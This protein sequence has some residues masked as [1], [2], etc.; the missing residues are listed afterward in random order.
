MCLCVC[1]CVCVCKCV[2]ECVSASLC[3]SVRECVCVCVSVCECVCE[4][5]CVSVCVCLC[6]CVYVCTCALACMSVCAG[7]KCGGRLVSID[8]SKSCR[9][10]SAYLPRSLICHCMCI[11][12]CISL[13][14]IAHF[15]KLFHFA[16]W[17]IF[18][19]IF[20]ICVTCDEFKLVEWLV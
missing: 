7:V 8:T 18:S 2:C 6:V 15:D 5:V 9:A 17:I 20:L 11:F 13:E 4:C 14:I 19:V 16:N 10:N 12:N 1:V 3:L